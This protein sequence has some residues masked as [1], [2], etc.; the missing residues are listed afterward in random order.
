M[1]VSS[2]P[3]EP[4]ITSV[5]DDQETCLARSKGAYIAILGQA[6][7]SAVT[8]VLGQHPELKKAYRQQLSLRTVDRSTTDD[9]IRRDPAP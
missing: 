1:A 9:Q 5:A 6:T 8:G 7:A 4:H 3:G 2:G